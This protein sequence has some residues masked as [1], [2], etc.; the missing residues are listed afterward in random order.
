[1]ENWSSLIHQAN[2]GFAEGRYEKSYCLYLQ[3]IEMAKQSWTVWFQPKQSCQAIVTSYHN[4]AHLLIKLD[5][6][7]EAQTHLQTLQCFLQREL[8]NFNG[9]N[10]VYSALQSAIDCNSL[11]LRNSFSCRKKA[12]H[13]VVAS[14]EN[15]TPS[16][17]LFD[18]N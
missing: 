11:A 2:L 3:S 16:S 5:R 17:T 4:L 12:I 9:S 13:R 7:G 18:I 15:L 14:R 8:K 1:M 6:H 10:Q